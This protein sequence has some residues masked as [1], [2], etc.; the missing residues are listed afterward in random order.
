M[1][2][3]FVELTRSRSGRNDSQTGIADADRLLND[4]LGK[5]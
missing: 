4:W 3:S 1:K 5:R 2:V